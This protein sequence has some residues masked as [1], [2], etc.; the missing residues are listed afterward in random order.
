M[1]SVTLVVFLFAWFVGSPA[2]GQMAHVSGTVTAQPRLQPKGGRPDG[3]YDDRGIRYARFFDYKHLKNVVVYAEPLASSA[4]ASSPLQNLSF[5]VRIERSG[6][7]P[8]IHPGF[9]AIPLGST[10]S[11]KNQTSHPLTLFAG[12]DS[13]DSFTLM[14]DPENEKPVVFNTVG[15]CRLFLLE[16]PLTRS[17]LFVAGSYVGLVDE[18][19][20]Y[21]L[22]LPAGRYKVTVWHERLPSQSEEI[23]LKEGEARPLDFSLLVLGQLPEIK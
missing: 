10:V 6:S 22:E 7:S 11:F 4:S 23:E 21:A 14:L 5:P 20:H 9:L 17:D 2:L 1:S 15:L 19:G 12:S 13:A 16:N 3:L 18:Q 8:K